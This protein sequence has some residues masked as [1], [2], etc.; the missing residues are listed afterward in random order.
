MA[1]LGRPADRDPKTGKTVMR[2]GLSHTPTYQ[3]WA[4]AIYRC[5][6]PN[7][8]FWALYGGRGIKVCDRWRYSF[9][10]FLSDIG[11]RPSVR[12]SI[13]RIDN[14][15]DYEPGNCRWATPQEQ[16]QNRRNTPRILGMSPRQLA[17]HTGLPITTIA[18]RIRRGWSPDRIAHQERRNYPEAANAHR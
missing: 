6:N 14:D 4:N 16:A 8:E 18:N 1:K 11:E 13:E 2:H 12:H 10:A 9:E 5:E 17:D 15:G 7:A 3:A